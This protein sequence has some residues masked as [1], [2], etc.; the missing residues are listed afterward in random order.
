MDV[1]KN[2]PLDPNM[3]G[4]FGLPLG[5]TTSGRLV[6]ASGAAGV[7]ISASPSPSELYRAH[8][9]RHIPSIRVQDGIIIVQYRRY[10]LL[11]RLAYLREPLACIGLNRAIP[12][13]IEFRDGVSRLTADL[14]KLH[15]RSLD[16][17]SV[18]TAMLNL[19]TPDGVANIYLSGS[20][21]DL[22]LQRPPGVGLRLQIAG[23]AS[24][25]RLDEQRFGAIGCGMRWQTQDYNTAVRRYEIGIAGSVGHMT[26]RILQE[27]AADSG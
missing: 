13:E 27:N 22:T 17:G 18:S 24:H 7:Q 19:P 20:A 9:E 8:F 2:L 23:A 25:L 16:L 5:K 4:D 12:W 14:R 21:T 3:N 6:F 26:I 15:L 1:L 11:D 10:L